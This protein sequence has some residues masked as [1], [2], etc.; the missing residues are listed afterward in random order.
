MPCNPTNHEVEPDQ[1]RGQIICSERIFIALIDIAKDRFESQESST[2]DMQISSRW[3]KKNMSL[4]F[5]I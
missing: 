5:K 4:I 2:P 1:S 3:R